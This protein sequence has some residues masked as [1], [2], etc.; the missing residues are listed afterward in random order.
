MLHK[1]GTITNGAEIISPDGNVTK[2][3]DTPV[4]LDDG[5]IVQANGVRAIGEGENQVIIGSKGSITH[6]NSAVTKNATTEHD[7]GAITKG[8]VTQHE[9][10][11]HTFSDGAI[12]LDDGKMAHLNGEV[13]S[14]DG[15]TVTPDG[16]TI[17]QDGSI[18]HSNG[19]ITANGVTSHKDGSKT[20]GNR[21]EHENGAIT[22]NDGHVAYPEGTMV[23]GK[24]GISFDNGNTYQQIRDLPGG[25]YTHPATGD[26]AYSN[27]SVYH[28]SSGAISNADGFIGRVNHAD[29]SGDKDGTFSMGGTVYWGNGTA[30]NPDKTVELD[31]HNSGIVVKERTIIHHSGTRTETK[32]G[33][34]KITREDG[35]TTFPK[36]EGNKN[37]KFKGFGLGS[38]KRK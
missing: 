34:T 35:Y 24:G 3:G 2:V 13:T 38:K 16:T 20:Y 30:A 8:N 4:K 12:L 36:K 21:V 31:E 33:E 25:Q 1:D 37:T 15:T 19:D 18:L 28:A 26:I 23:D 29:G 27:G 11:N 7:S 9:N 5:T 22:Y 10:G 32:N 17:F 14:P 6:G